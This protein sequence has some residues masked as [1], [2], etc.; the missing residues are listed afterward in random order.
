MSSLSRPQQNLTV[1]LATFNSA[2]SPVGGG[3]C[4]AQTA[5]AQL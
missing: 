1:F 4:C 5:L 3:L 2:Q